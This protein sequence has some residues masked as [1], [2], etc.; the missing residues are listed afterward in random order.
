[1]GAVH[2]RLGTCFCIYVCV[3]VSDGIWGCLGLG[4]WGGNVEEGRKDYHGSLTPGME[5]QRN[6]N[7]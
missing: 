6:L 7:A 1:M 3:C 4:L 2:K 5:L